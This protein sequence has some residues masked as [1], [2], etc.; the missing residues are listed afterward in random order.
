MTSSGDNTSIVIIDLDE[1]WSIVKQMV[2]IQTNIKIN[3]L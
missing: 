3:L 2:H 1:P